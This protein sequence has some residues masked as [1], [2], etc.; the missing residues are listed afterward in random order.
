MGTTI[1]FANLHC[2]TTEDTFGADEPVLR[3]NG[4]VIWEGE[5]NDGDTVNV[6]RFIPLNDESGIIS[7]TERDSPDPDDHLGDQTIFRDEANQGW[8]RA[9]FRGDD[10][11]YFLDYHVF[12]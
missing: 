11:S 1:Q 10:A 2:D 7:L 12:T 5:L 9:N 8:H 6:D 4:S 3:W